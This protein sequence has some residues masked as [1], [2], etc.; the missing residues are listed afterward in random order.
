MVAT[1]PMRSGDKPFE[2]MK[3]VI[4]NA[5]TL[6]SAMYPLNPDEE[7]TATLEKAVKIEDAE[8]RKLVVSLA[9]SIRYAMRTKAEYYE[10]ARGLVKQLET[11]QAGMKTA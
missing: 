6:H 5:K 11:V 8:T 2:Q 1:M 3:T 4:E 9:S 10:A 7:Y